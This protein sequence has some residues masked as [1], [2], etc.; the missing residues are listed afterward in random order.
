MA[1]FI[2]FLLVLSFLFFIVV[3]IGHSISVFLHLEE[4]FAGE[5]FVR[6]LL[7]GLLAIPFGY[8]IIKTGGATILAGLLIPVFFYWKKIRLIPQFT[9]QV[10]SKSY[11]SYFFIGLL[12]C[13]LFSLVEFLW[14]FDRSTGRIINVPHYDFL[15]YARLSNFLHLTGGENMLFLQNL[16]EPKAHQIREP[17]HY[18]E[19]WLNAF[20]IAI[21]GKSAL[22]TLMLLI[23]PILKGSLVMM[24]IVFLRKNFLRIRLTYAIISGILLTGITAFY[25]SF[26]NNNPLLQ[27]YDGITQSGALMSFGRKYLFMAISM[28]YALFFMLS[29]KRYVSFFVLIS[30][31]TLFSVGVAPG[32]LSILFIGPIVLYLRKEIS[33]NHLLK[34]WSFSLL[35]LS[36][37]FVFYSILSDKGLTKEIQESLWIHKMISHPEASLFKSFVF[38]FVF[39]LMRVF[40]FY[41][42][43]LLLIFILIR[44]HLSFVVLFPLFLAVI[45]IIGGNVAASFASGALDNGQFLYNTLPLLNAVLIYVVIMVISQDNYLWMRY[46]TIF[47]SIAVLTFSY[48]VY[49]DIHHYR[50]A[51]KPYNAI[52]S[53]IRI[54]NSDN[55]EAH[56]KGKFI[57]GVYKEEKQMN[58]DYRDSQY[59]FSHFYLQFLDRY[60]D[61]VRIDIS[62]YVQRMEELSPVDRFLLR[63][64]EFYRYLSKEKNHAIEATIPGFIQSIQPDFMAEG[65]KIFSA[66]EKWPF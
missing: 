42:P 40:F 58:S 61:V 4:K 32:V 57:K 12:L 6:D 60:T 30:L 9:R 51:I 48:H 21:T 38:S 3:I 18:P 44:K 24:V 43:Y 23:Y 31:N 7:L 46:R 50:S 47:F 55:I 22:K 25:F 34:I 59:R 16:F 15:Y 20:A 63:K 27:Y 33:R 64:N 29:E 62:S 10:F 41:A 53:E 39:P 52:P 56:S 45:A 5:R 13:Y 11:I 36:F 65:D 14:I 19:M 2:Y 35:I 28:A 17:Y 1:E 37:Q 54:V 49:C 66:G 26:Y 8:A